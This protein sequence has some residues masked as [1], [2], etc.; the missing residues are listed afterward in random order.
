MVEVIK[1]SFISFFI[2]I[3]FVCKVSRLNLSL[4]CNSEFIFLIM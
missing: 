2:L 1:Y 3:S 4:I